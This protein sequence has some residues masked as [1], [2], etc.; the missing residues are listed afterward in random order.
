MVKLISVSYRLVQMFTV[1]FMCVC[2]KVKHCNLRNRL[3][4]KRFRAKTKIFI[5]FILERRSTKRL[6]AYPTIS[7]API[8]FIRMISL[9][10]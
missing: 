5:F 10:D 3:R 1:V 2:V 9:A 4:G 7:K 8:A 6:L